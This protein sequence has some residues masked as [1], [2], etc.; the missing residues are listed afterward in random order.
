[1]HAQKSAFT[2]TQNLEFVSILHLVGE[3]AFE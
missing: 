3:A 1:M 2:N